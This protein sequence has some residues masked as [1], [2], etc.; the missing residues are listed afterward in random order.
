MTAKEEAFYKYAV[1][2]G[3]SARQALVI[4]DGQER[5]LLQILK[6]RWEAWSSGYDACNQVAKQTKDG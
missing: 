2:N 6:I 5:G 3:Y 4:L 1:K